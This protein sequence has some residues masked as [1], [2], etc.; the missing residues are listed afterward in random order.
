ME[1]ATGTDVPFER[2]PSA[3]YA[4]ARTALYRKGC[5]IEILGS[6]D[7]KLLYVAEWWKQLYGESEGQGGQRNFPG[8]RDADGRTCTR[9]GSTFSR[10]S[11][12]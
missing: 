9:W 5:K 11:G 1:K 2:N 6:Y 7:P 3:L 4:A 8:Q 12:R 10:A